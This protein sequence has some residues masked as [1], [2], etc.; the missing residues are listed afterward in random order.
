MAQPV[1]EAR[2]TQIRGAVIAVAREGGDAAVARRVSRQARCEPGAS[3]DRAHGGGVGWDE[4]LEPPASRLQAV[5]R[6]DQPADDGEIHVRAL[7]EID[8]DASAV[9]VAAERRSEQ[10]RVAEIVLPDEFDDRD[11]GLGVHPDG[12]RCGVL[13]NGIRDRVAHERVGGRQVEWEDRIHRALRF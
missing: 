3:R 8:Q 2:A 6:R 4:E 11:A 1:E 10:V 5:A 7:R 9:A 13:G 12:G